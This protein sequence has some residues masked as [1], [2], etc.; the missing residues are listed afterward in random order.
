MIIGMPDD[1]EPYIKLVDL[2]VKSVA[3]F[4]YWVKLDEEI[5]ESYDELDE[6]ERRLCIDALGD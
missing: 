4:A 3:K 6:S 1:E 5:A 2:D